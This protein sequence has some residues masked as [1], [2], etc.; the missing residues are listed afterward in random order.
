MERAEEIWVKLGL[1]ELSLREPTAGYELGAWTEE[2][3]E[4]ARLAEL[5]RYLET[6]AKLARREGTGG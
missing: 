2:N 1:P 3:R 4:E 6:G 5:G